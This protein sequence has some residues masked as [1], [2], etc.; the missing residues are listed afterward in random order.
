MLYVS[1]R[2]KRLF[3]IYYLFWINSLSCILICICSSGFV[4]LWITLLFMD[5]TYN[6]SSIKDHAYARSLVL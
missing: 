6:Y 3:L 1:E 4:L 2:V 5:Y